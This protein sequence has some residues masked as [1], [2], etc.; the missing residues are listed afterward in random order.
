MNKDVER[1][2]FDTDEFRVEGEAEERSI[3]GHAALFDTLSADLGGFREK[4]D[5]GAFDNADNNDVRAL[6]NHDPNLVLGRNTAGTLLL[7]E[8]EKG[9]R[10]K[11]N[12]PDTVFANDLMKSIDRGDI[13]QM[14]F[15]FRVKEDEWE[16]GK[17][18]EPS[19]RTLK[20]VELFDVSPVTYPAYKQTDVGVR[21]LNDVAEEGRKRLSDRKAVNYS[22]YENIQLHAEKQ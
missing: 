20:K 7:D 19:V 10:V 9:L 5:K 12:P 3:V 8:D 1:R 11:I 14:S 6:F 13:S 18:D 2:A 21:S 16:K 22:N 17:G 4:I 15:G